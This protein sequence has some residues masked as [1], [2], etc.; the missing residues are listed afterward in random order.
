MYGN[1]TNIVR[2]T[3]I[4]TGFSGICGGTRAGVIRAWGGVCDIEIIDPIYNSRAAPPCPIVR[5]FDCSTPNYASCRTAGNG[6]DPDPKACKPVEGVWRFSA[7]GLTRAALDALADSASAEPPYVPQCSTADDLTDVQAKY[8]R[9]T[10]TLE[11]LDAGRYPSTVDAAALAGLV[12]GKLELLVELHGEELSPDKRS[13][14]HG[15]YASRPAY[16]P[17]CGGRADVTGA[18]A[19]SG[20]LAMCDRLTQTHVKQPA[21]M[22]SAGACVDAAAQLPSAARPAADAYLAAVQRVVAKAVKELPATAAVA[23]QSGLAER[24]AL[25]QRWYDSV[26]NLYG[27]NDPRALLWKDTSAV[28]GAIAQGAYSSAMD[29]F[30]GSPGCASAEQGISVDAAKLQALLGST[31]EGDREVLTAAFPKSGTAPLRG[32]PLAFVVANALRPAATRLQAIAPIHD[33]AC[34]MKDCRANG[35]T[36]EISQMVSLMGSAHDRA[37]LSAALAAAGVVR[38]SWRSAL[39]GLASRH[40]VLEWAL[41]DAEGIPTS[42][43]G[44]AALIA[45][46]VAA[47]PAG[48]SLP[49]MAMSDVVVPTARLADRYSARGTFVA[50]PG[51]LEAGL[52]RARYAEI[53]PVVTGQESGLVAAIS[54]YRLGRSAL[55]TT[56]VQEI[57]GK[58]TQQS[59]VEAINRKRA[60]LREAAN[61]LAALRSSAASDGE[62][63]ASIAKA[64]QGVLQRYPSTSEYFVD[65]LPIAPRTVGVFDARYAG[66]AVQS[67]TSLTTLAP[68]SFEA[69]D[70]ARLAVSGIWSPTCAIRTAGTLGVPPFQNPIVFDG[71]AGA[72]TGPEGFSVTLSSGT[73]HAQATSLVQSRT[74]SVCE[75]LTGSIPITTPV[76]GAGATYSASSTTCVSTTDTTSRSDGLDSRLAATFTQGLRLRNTPFPSAPAGSLL[77]VVMPRGVVNLGNVIDVVVLRSQLSLVIPQAADVYLV[78]ND[79]YGCG[80]SAGSLLVEGVR[81]HPL[82]SRVRSMGLAM[83]SALQKIR[84][85]AAK[86]VAERRLLPQTVALLKGIA[87]QELGTTCACAPS[88]YPR[89]LLSFYEVWVDAVIA[90]AE[91]QVE[92]ANLLREM[93]L[94]DMDAR[95]LNED[96]QRARY[97]GALLGL[98]PTWTLQ[99]LDAA[100][101]GERSAALANATATTLF[102]FIR[103][104][105]PETIDHVASNRY[106]NATGA[107]MQAILDLDWTREFDVA[108]EVLADATARLRADLD[109][110]VVDVAAPSATDVAVAFVRPGA[111][112]DPAWREADPARAA[113]LWEAIGATSL[114]VPSPRIGTF[115][116]TPEDLYSATGGNSVLLCSEAAPIIR[117]MG[118]YIAW[119]TDSECQDFN[120]W[121]RR[122]P[123]VF[124]GDPM[125]YPTRAGV[126]SFRFD[127]AGGWLNPSVNVTC[128]RWA[129]AR[130]HFVASPAYQ[131]T[132]AGGLSPFDDITVDFSSFN[133]GDD[134]LTED[135]QAL[136]VWFRL[137]PRNITGSVAGVGGC[138]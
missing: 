41:A 87:Q 9:L 85:E 51:T 5:T 96:L 125:H 94:V 67:I 43:P 38:A 15:L 129:L 117:T 60:E 112:V 83:G 124:S 45:G 84:D 14:I 46:R 98:I 13:F 104:V 49:V 16:G 136:V 126:E 26:K 59:I 18:G 57:Q 12:V 130:T 64:Y 81:L 61:D 50:D 82:G 108:A 120:N 21:A 89:E 90:D 58:R 19:L 77:A 93:R 110:T 53:R 30:C 52:D 105:Y 29:A 3:I 39:D 25:V 123:V 31:L 27:G 2:A 79:L 40:D 91:R 118:L 55:A 75:G 48:A 28:A 56:L 97:E 134:W 63:F 33:V 135:A 114:G 32:A 54:S 22:A 23:R 42:T 100:E 47:P 102:P 10:Q 111:V 95:A 103:I 109:Q 11:N 17:T 119:P 127:D 24:L 7:F 78:V 20:G 37:R 65:P 8:T 74:D 101:I 92:A 115:R 73:Y 88:T 107:R 35:T 86:H 121:D 72:N 128:G 4:S 113:A 80:T 132:T 34:L 137:E 76:L 138:P 1:D 106:A 133:T 122:V 131:R 6:L 68:I 44:I 116:I 36:T 62:Q 99:G 70:L 69:G 71:V 66:S